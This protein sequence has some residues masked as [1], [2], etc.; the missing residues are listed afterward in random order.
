MVLSKEDEGLR[1][2]WPLAKVIEV[3][4]SEDGYVRRVK[5]MKADAEL[6]NQGRRL[7][8]AIFLDRPVHKLVLL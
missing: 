2:Q 4:P 1:N 3:Y 7:K 6:D 8:P 5:I